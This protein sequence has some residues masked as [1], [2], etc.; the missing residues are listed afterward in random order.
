VLMRL[1]VI[2]VSHWLVPLSGFL[3]RWMRMG[4]VGMAGYVIV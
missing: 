3:V 2:G 4:V 1:G